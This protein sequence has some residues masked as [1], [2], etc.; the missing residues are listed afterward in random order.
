MNVKKLK[1]SRFYKHC[2]P[3]FLPCG[4]CSLPVAR[5]SMSRWVLIVS[6]WSVNLH[7]LIKHKQIRL[8]GSPGFR[9]VTMHTFHLRLNSNEYRVYLLNVSIQHCSG[10][11]VMFCA[12]PL[13]TKWKSPNS[14]N[15]TLL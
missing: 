6:V 7:A 4:W 15:Y 12:Y 8:C 10:Q 2:F 14:L 9:I 3:P 1:H 13:S 11:P 5:G